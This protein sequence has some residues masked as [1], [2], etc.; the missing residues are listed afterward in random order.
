MNTKFIFSIWIFLLLSVTACQRTDFDEIMRK[1]QQ[2]QDQLDSQA[3]RI[4]ALE[5]AVKLMNTDITALKAITSALQQ[6]I[7]IVS[8]KATSTGYTLTMSNGTTINLSNGKDGS[9][10][11]NG[12]NGTNG[13]D[14]VNAPAI[15]VKQDT[16]GLYYWT[17]GGNF[18]IQNG[19]KLP[20][21][22]KDGQNGSNGITPLL[23]VNTTAI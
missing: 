20:V 10:G 7:S 12:T 1:Q 22:G 16:D 6:N 9:N 8:Y 3:A 17:L 4:A 5:A 21:T 14:G 15:G 2:Q 23:Q 11:T 18:I 19:N 13:K